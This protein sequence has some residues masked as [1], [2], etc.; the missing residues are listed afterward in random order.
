ME[1]NKTE[2]TDPDVL[3]GV[4]KIKEDFAINVL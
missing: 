3:D 2:D 4:D 1:E